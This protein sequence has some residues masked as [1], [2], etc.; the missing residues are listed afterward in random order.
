V[1]AANNVNQETILFF[2]IVGGLS[3]FSS[4]QPFLAT[5]VWKNGN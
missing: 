2:I 3:S 5:E 1:K 4:L